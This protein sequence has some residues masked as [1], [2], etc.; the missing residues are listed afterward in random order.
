[1]FS[2]IKKYVE[3]YETALQSDN[4]HVNY[5]GE[6]KHYTELADFDSMVSYWM[7]EEV[8]Y[9]VDAYGISSYFSK[10]VG[11]KIVMGPV[12]D[13]DLSMGDTT[14]GDFSQFDIWFTDSANWWP[15]YML[16]D[17]YFY[18]KCQEYY[19]A[20]RDDLVEMVQDNGLIDTYAAKIY[21]SAVKDLQMWHARSDYDTYTDKVKEWMTKRI[22]WLD[23]QFATEDSITA[24]LGTYKRANDTL[25][26]TAKDDF[27]QNLLGDTMTAK[28]SA[29]SIC[30]TDSDISMNVSVDN[31]SVKSLEVSVNTDILGQYDIKDSNVSFKIAKALLDEAIGKKNIITVCGYDDK[32]NCIARHFYTVVLVEGKLERW[33][34]SG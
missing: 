21:D 34:Y 32:G 25:A 31:V 2:Y 7:V 13:M 14:N 11:G 26:I 20:H 4:G 19:W 17:P 22:A 29:S 9:D 5:E 15:H 16:S 12:W 28:E 10:D 24:S 8:L 27:G 3:A 33:N 23:E 6:K 30:G 18:L 1:M